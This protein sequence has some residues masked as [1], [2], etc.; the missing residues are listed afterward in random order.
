M[1]G[2]APC[3]LRGLKTW[4]TD[5][6][7]ASRF[8]MRPPPMRGRHRSASRRRIGQGAGWRV[9]TLRG[10]RTRTSR[11]RGAASGPERRSAGASAPFLGRLVYL[12]VVLGLWGVIGVGGLVAYHAA[13]LPPI[14]QLTVPK[15][16]PNIAI[17]AAD[18]SL[19]ANRGETGGRTV[20]HQGAA[21]LSAARPSWRSRTGAST[22]ISASTRSASPARSCSNLTRGAASRRAAR[23]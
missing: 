8:S 13:Q 12:G 7:G 5:V 6:T 3:G 11:R 9:A 1:K 17:L 21:A 18:G 15:R 23:R 10:S 4:R 20:T 2:Q 19:L 16:P 22:S 14:D